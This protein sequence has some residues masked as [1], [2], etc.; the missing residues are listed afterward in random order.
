[1]LGRD[2]LYSRLAGNPPADFYES[3][4]GQNSSRN[5]NVTVRY[6]VLER[7]V[8]FDTKEEQSTGT[9]RFGGINP[10]I[11][12]FRRSTPTAASSTSSSFRPG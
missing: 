8:P 1:M 6:L 9:E 5:R 11:P 4:R 2:Y 7:N 3:L 10:Q 12:L